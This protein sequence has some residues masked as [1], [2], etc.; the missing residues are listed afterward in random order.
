[1]KRLFSGILILVFILSGICIP[2]VSASADEEDTEYKAQLLTS[3]GVLT[4]EMLADEKESITR[5]E[6]CNI[7]MRMM[8]YPD[9]AVLSTDVQLFVDVPANHYAAGSINL[10]Y[11]KGIMTGSGSRMFQPEDAVTYEQALKI[12]VGVLGWTKY[13][14]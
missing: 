1:M 2:Q 8:G 12:M 13:S 5:G 11:S 6:F 3:L 10:A 4:P 14:D 7:A 9:A